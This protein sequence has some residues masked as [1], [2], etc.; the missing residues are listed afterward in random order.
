MTEYMSTQK[1]FHTIVV[2]SKAPI[3]KI[4]IC[5]Y[6]SGLLSP[7]LTPNNAKYSTA[8]I[9]SQYKHAKF[10]SVAPNLL[11]CSTA[12]HLVTLSFFV[13]FPCAL[14]NSVPQQPRLCL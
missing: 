2:L 14:G 9:L 3:E 8:L 4:G 11:H 1:L 10:L 6:E 5:Y 7:Y 12:Y 13:D